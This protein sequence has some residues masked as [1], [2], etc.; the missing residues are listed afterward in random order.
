MLALN[1]R[2]LGFPAHLA[3]G[4]PSLPS[5]VNP[6]PSILVGCNQKVVCI[7][8]QGKGSFQNSGG[9][10]TFATAMIHRGHREFV[11][12]LGGC[13]VMDSTFMGTLTGVALRLRELGHGGL[14]VVN[15]N[16]RNVDL[17]QGLGLDQILSL[18]LNGTEHPFNGLDQAEN[19]PEALAAE[20]LG[21]REMTETMI[22]AHQALVDADRQNFH[23]F[24]NVIDYLKQDLKQEES[25]D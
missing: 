14:H 7:R 8:V 18:E 19:C 15:A 17:L 5:P 16:E 9:V 3:G 10:K 25:V 23:K 11:V 2:P 12:D 1:E 20:P 24:K 22:A 21:K 4:Y 6:P 13:P